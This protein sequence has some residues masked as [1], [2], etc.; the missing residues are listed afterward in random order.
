MLISRPSFLFGTDSGSDK[1]GGVVAALVSSCFAA[2]AFICIKANGKDAHPI[3]TALWFHTIS[4]SGSVI[5][6]VFGLPFPASF[7]TPHEALLLSILVAMSFLGQL[8]LSRGFQLLNPSVAAA[9]N[10]CQVVHARTL[11]VLFLGDDLPWTGVA[12][13]ILIGGG[14]LSTQLGKQKK[15]DVTLEE[16][17]DGAGDTVRLIEQQGDDEKVFTLTASDSLKDQSLELVEGLDPLAAGVDDS[18]GD[19]PLSDL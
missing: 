12:G 10:L 4:A 18:N 5:P 15:S 9:I 19:E 8:L 13:S 2:G 11:C 14:V 6:M 7:P 1:V 17:P 16:R 3:T